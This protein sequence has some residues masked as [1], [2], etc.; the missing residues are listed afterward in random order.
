MTS[1]SADSPKHGTHIEEDDETISISRTEK[2]EK[3]T[4]TTTY[5]YQKDRDEDD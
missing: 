5:T 2:T 4:K 1:R 3:G